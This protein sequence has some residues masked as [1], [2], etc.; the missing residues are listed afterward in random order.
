MTIQK[1]SYI[2]TLDS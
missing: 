2:P 1:F